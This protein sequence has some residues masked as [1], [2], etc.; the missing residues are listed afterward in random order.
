MAKE[1]KRVSSD[2]PKKLRRLREE[3]GLSQGQVAKKIGIE[4]QRISKYERGVLYPT[5]EIMLRLVGIFDISLDYLLRG[6]K[7]A[8]PHSI[9]NK[10]L[11]ERIKRLDELPKEKQ[12]LLIAILDTFIKE[13]Q[14]EQLIQS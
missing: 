1:P 6:Q 14:L 7:D 8:D 13:Y 2:F 5:T 9:K 3:K 12:N 10:D 11:F 4:S